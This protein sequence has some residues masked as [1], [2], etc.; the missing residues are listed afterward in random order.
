MSEKKNYLTIERLNKIPWLIHGFGLAGFQL[1]ELKAE[2][3]LNY[4]EPVEMSQQ[5]SARVLFIE[6]FPAHKLSGDGLITA[7]S[8]LLLIIKTADCLPIFL[9]DLE[10]RAVA[11]IHCGWRG[12]A[13]KIVIKAFELMQQ[14]FNSQARNMLA[15]L[16]PCIEQNCYEVG[17]EVLK[18]FTQAGFPVDLFFR[19]VRI[20]DKFLLDLRGT[21]YWLLS[22][23]LGIPEENILQKNLCTF[24]HP[25][26]ISYRRNKEQKERLINFIG[27]KK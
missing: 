8:G 13:Q 11:A 18:I 15:A 27:I 7:A 23:V 26:L 20:A 6:N 10:N 12:T 16:G 24:C 25:G 2:S 17:N 22:R 21:N 5:H 14:K 3:G 19:P 1:Q 9:I 4:F